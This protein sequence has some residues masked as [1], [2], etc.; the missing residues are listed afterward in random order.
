[1]KRCRNQDNAI[2][3]T[4]RTRCHTS[5]RTPSRLPHGGD[6]AW[7]VAVGAQPCGRG[8]GIE[9]RGAAVPSHHPE[10]LADRGG[11]TIRGRHR[12]GARPDPRG[13]GA[14]GKSP[15]DAG[16]HAAH[17]CLG[18]RGAS[19]DGAY[20]L[21]VPAPLSRHDGRHRPP[22]GGWSISWS[23]VSM[24]ACASRNWCRRT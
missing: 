2:F 7:H 3:R 22:K 20:H 23:M 12:P 19:D 17:Q 16:G 14:G 15:G 8:V 1:M 21:R 24:P 11:R 10:R 5:G 9:A 6:R 18:R 4:G 13:D